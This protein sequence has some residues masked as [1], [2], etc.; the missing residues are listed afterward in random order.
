MVRAQL[1]SNNLLNT[2]RCACNLHCRAS[3]QEAHTGRLTFDTRMR[4][5]GLHG[6]RIGVLIDIFR[7]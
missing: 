3:V 1:R 6:I 7:P 5:A 2:V 4:K